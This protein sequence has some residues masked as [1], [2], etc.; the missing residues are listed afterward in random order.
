MKHP[1][2]AVTLALPLSA[3]VVWTWFR[4]WKPVSDVYTRTV[5][6]NGV[7]IFG[8]LM[9]VLSVFDRFAKST[10]WV[11]QVYDDILIA[12]PL[13]MWGGYWWGRAMAWMYGQRPSRDVA[14]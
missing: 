10:P 1:F 9:F 4:L 13:C 14:A 12:L 2:L 5:Y 11:L 7:R 6:C 3:F 8:F